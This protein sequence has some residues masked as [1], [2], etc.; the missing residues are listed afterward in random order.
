MLAGLCDSTVTVTVKP[1]YD[2]DKKLEQ[3]LKA[4]FT[5]DYSFESLEDFLDGL[6]PAPD[7]SQKK[8]LLKKLKGDYE[9]DLETLEAVFGKSPDGDYDVELFYIHR[10]KNGE[11]IKAFLPEEGLDYMLQEI[12]KVIIVET[13][14]AIKL[15]YEED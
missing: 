8:L 2:Y 12:R 11:L 13:K 6:S 14:T 4:I 7:A 1:S 5:E 10:I 9:K 3:A 15:D